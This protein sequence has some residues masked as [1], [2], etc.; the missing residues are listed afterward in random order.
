MPIKIKINK[1][2]ALIN[3]NQKVTYKV[4]V[5]I[6]CPNDDILKSDYDTFHSKLACHNFGHFK[7]E[8]E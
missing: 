2:K 8:F 3:H 1:N 7:L 4:K 6:K 5:E